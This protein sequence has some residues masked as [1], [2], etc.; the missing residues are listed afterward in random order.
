MVLGIDQLEHGDDLTYLVR[1][2]LGLRCAYRSDRIDP[3]GP[4]ES[5][6]GGVA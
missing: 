1:L 3:I 5:S 2:R 6:G 4:A